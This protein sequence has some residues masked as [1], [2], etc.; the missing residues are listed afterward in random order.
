MEKN[1]DKRK[2]KSLESIVKIEEQIRSI[3]EPTIKIE[4]PMVKIEQ[5]IIKIEETMVHIKESMIK[6]EDSTVDIEETR[7]EIVERLINDEYKYWKSSTPFLYDLLISHAFEWPSLTIEWLPFRVQLS[8]APYSIQRVILGTCTTNGEPNYLIIAQV[9]LPLLD[10]YAYDEEYGAGC[11][12]FKIEVLQQIHHDGEVL[13]ARHMPQDPF[14]IASKTLSS[15]VHIFDYRNHPAKP[16]ISGTS[17]PDVRLVGH[18]S[19]GFGLSWS[20][21]NRGFLLSGS[22]DAK[23]CLWDINQTP[24]NKA[25]DALQTFEAHR[26]C[27]EDV[28]W[29]LKHNY[30]F[31]SC[32][33]DRY[34]HIYDLRTPCFIR[35]V[36]SLKAHQNKINCL[37]FNPINEWLVA[38]G[39][40]DN[41]LKFFDLRKF[42]API[43]TFNHHKDEVVQIGWSPHYEN[44]LA[45]SCAGRRLMIWDTDRIGLEQLANNSEDGPPELLFIHG[46][47]TDRIP[48]F[49]W[50]PTEDWVIA[51]VSDNILQVWQMGDHIYS[52]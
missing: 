25:I 30:L 7:G 52:D 36:Q 28:A 12:D 3:E 41:T 11:D 19:G 39:A 44:I 51:S 16:P 48:D 37:S 46:G 29:H 47:H 20:T 34:L 1:A 6:G 31:G 4:E 17:I 2:V 43:H 15:G 5:P 18:C 13:R 27:V 9:K 32:G 14:I 24:L 22:K 23:I 38:T 35:P 45:S 42:S 49:S 10:D 26:D 8:N 50:N 40:S 33:V 21:I